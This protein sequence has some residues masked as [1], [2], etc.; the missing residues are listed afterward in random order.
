MGRLYKSAD[1]Y[2]GSANRYKEEKEAVAGQTT[3]NVQL[4]DELRSIG[5]VVVTAFGQSKKEASQRGRQ[6]ADHEISA[7]NKTHK[8]RKQHAAGARIQVRMR[9][10]RLKQCTQNDDRNG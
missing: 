10:L 9:R 5:E 3:I 1:S 6:L 8:H 7:G 2:K 4:V